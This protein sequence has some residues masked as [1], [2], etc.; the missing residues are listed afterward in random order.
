MIYTIWAQRKWGSMHRAQMGS[1]P[2]PL[3]LLFHFFFKLDFGVLKE[4]VCF[5][6][7]LLSSLLFVLSNSYVI[8]FV[9]SYFLLLL[10][11]RSLIFFSNERHKWSRFPQ[12]GGDRH[13][14]NLEGINGEAT[15]TYTHKYIYLSYIYMINM[16][17]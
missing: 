16:Y 1:A 14:K 13:G 12:K 8:I 17:P 10:S 5:L 11:L 6:C 9:L 3:Y 15:V 4:L 2:C 7:P